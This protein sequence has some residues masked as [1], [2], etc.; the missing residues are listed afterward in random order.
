MALPDD[1]L[2]DVVFRRL[3]PRSLDA[4]RCVCKEWRDVINSRRI[5]RPEL[6]PHSVCGISLELYYPVFLARPSAGPAIAGKL[7]FVLDPSRSNFATVLD[8]CN[9][10]LLYED[11][12]G[13]YV[14]NAATQWWARLPPAPWTGCILQHIARLVFDPTESTHYEVFIVPDS[15]ERGEVVKRCWLAMNT[16][17][18]SIIHGQTPLQWECRP[19][20]TEEPDDRLTEWPP[21]SNVL[22]VFSSQTGHWEERA[23]AREGKAAGTV[24]DMRLQ[25]GSWF[26]L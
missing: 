22:Y 19:E 6:L 26:T 24:A 4:A 23:F 20:D 1:A 21:L 16:S 11:E 12:Q 17:L 25:G 3:A 7:D 10:L 8:H 9:G 15:P 14:L 5:L 13:L 18:A 2:A